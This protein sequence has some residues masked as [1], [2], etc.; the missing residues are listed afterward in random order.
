MLFITVCWKW[1]DVEVG[2]GAGRGEGNG[3]QTTLLV[4]Q[5]LAS[6]ARYFGFSST[7]AVSEKRNNFSKI[8]NNRLDSA[9]RGSPRMGHLPL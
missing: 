8:I 1:G 4:F 3:P 9:G 5:K 6:G 7:H 2:L